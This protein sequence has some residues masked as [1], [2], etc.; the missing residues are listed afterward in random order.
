MLS[1][2]AFEDVPAAPSPLTLATYRLS[3]CSA[4]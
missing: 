4:R 2:T 1:E 3:G